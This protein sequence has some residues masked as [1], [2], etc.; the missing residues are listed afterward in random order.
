MD[1]SCKSSKRR[2][3]PVPSKCSNLKTRHIGLLTGS[4]ASQDLIPRA[5]II[6]RTVADLRPGSAVNGYVRSPL[7]GDQIWMPKATVGEVPVQAESVPA[8]LG[9][10]GELLAQK[11]ALL[12]S[13]KNLLRE[14]YA[15]LDIRRTL[16]S[17]AYLPLLNGQ[18]MAGAIEILSFE[19]EITPEHLSALRPVAEISAAALMAA[20]G[21]EMER[22]DSLTSVS[23]LTQLYDLEKVFASTLEMDELLPIIGSKLSE[24][25]GRKSVNVWLLQADES[26]EL[27]HQAGFDPTTLPHM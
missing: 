26:L 5:R 13:G 1:T 11:E 12:L 14:K 25:L 6:A 3:S 2:G 9:T 10:L 18:T 8:G 4:L 15:H 16:L 23:R 17:L 24:V 27:M 7:D 22:H 21:Y 20:Q 19:K